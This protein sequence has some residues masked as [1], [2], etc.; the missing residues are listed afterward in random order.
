M[1]VALWCVLVLAVASLPM[2]DWMSGKAI[3]TRWV[4]THV[5]DDETRAE[6][7]VTK[8]GQEAKAME[9]TYTRKK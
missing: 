3:M 5:S 8:D 2:S 7:F 9:L 6:M 1:R 4:N